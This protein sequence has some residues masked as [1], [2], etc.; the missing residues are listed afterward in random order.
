MAARREVVSALRVLARSSSTSVR[1]PLAVAFD[2]DGVLKQGENVLP[3]A[4]RAIKLLD[5]DNQW[6]QKVPYVFI[7]NGGGKPEMTR[8]KDL[9]AEL[10]VD[11]SPAQV[12][13][14]HTVMQAL[15]PKFAQ[16]PILMIGGPDAEAGAARAVLEGCVLHE[17]KSMALTIRYGFEKV[18]TA[19]DLHAFAPAS[20]PY[21]APDARQQ[22]AIKV[23]GG[24]MRCSHSA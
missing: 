3:E 7:T 14:A 20:W 21:S 1:H 23:C 2:I 17:M 9:S 22:S 13:Q 11:V 6:N 10:G 24:N 19:H 8:A 18:Y 12:V 15:L 5:G 4:R 16:K